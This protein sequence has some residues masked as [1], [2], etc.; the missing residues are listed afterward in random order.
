[1]NPT[2]DFT[3]N[4]DWKIQSSVE[5]TATGVELST[6]PELTGNWFPA[7]IPSTVLGILAENKI[8][9]NP[10]YG[11][12]LKVIPREPFKV[13]WWYVTSFRI[14]E[15]LEGYYGQLL[16]DGINYSANIWLNGHLV[17]D[18]QTVNGAY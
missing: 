1:M 4:E 6:D 11:E 16:L 2:I 9:E 18:T 8:Y 12:N 7:R 3:L 17:A 10:Y 5:V 13:P 15:V 14:D